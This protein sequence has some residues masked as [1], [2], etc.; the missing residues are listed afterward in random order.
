[1]DIPGKMKTGLELTLAT[2]FICVIMA[3]GP[4]VW[5]VVLPL[6]KDDVQKSLMSCPCRLGTACKQC[7]LSGSSVPTEI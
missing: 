6:G 2:S 5:V 7:G 1:M 4:C 3:L